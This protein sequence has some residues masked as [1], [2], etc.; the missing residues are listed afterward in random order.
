MRAAFGLLTAL[1]LHWDPDDVRTAW[2]WTPLVGLALGV[3]WLVFHQAFVRLGGPFVAA[4]GVLLLHLALTGARPLRGLAGVV[5]AVVDDPGE[6]RRAL[7][8][9]GGAAAAVIAL[10]LLTMSSFLIRVDVA[11]AVL[12]VVPLV[13]R[14]VQVVLLGP[15]DDVGVRPPVTGQRVA[16]LLGT[17]LALAVPPAMATLVRPIR[18]DAPVAGAGYA[19]LGAAAL[20]VALAAGWVARA[21]LRARLGGLDANGWHAVGAVADLAA[22]GVVASRIS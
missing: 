9:V 19:L 21:W 6:G 12:V 7:P 15:D 22:L 3:A 2:P 10:V 16:V 20:V 8:D 5:A 18:L 1:P 4:G 14:A 13:G 11:P 17:A